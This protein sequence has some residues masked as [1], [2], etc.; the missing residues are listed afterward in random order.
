M[1]SLLCLLLATSA[2]PAFICTYIYSSDDCSGDVKSTSC[3]HDGKCWES[4]VPLIEQCTPGGAETIVFKYE[5]GDSDCNGTVVSQDTLSNQG[6]S[7][8][9]GGATIQT[10]CE[11]ALPTGATLR[12]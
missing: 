5:A 8:L 1:K 9:P 3:Y 2:A 10:A 4:D 11:N 12:A 6:C 7:S